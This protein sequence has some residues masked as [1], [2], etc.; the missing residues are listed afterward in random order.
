M[1]IKT[2]MRILPHSSQIGHHQKVYKNKFW[3]GRGALNL[4]SLLKQLQLSY[5]YFSS[6]QS[7]SHVGLFPPHEPQHARPPCPSPTPGV[8]QNPRPLSRWCHPTILSSVV[9]FSSCP[10]SF[11]PSGSFQVSQLFT[12]GG[13]S[14]GVSASTSVLP[15]NTQD[16]SPLGWTGW[17][18][19]QSKG[20]SRDFSNTTVQKHQFFGAQPS[21]QS[22]SHIHTWRLEKP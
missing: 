16:W 11:L 15:M 20:L 10:Q 22:N 7:L 14:I 3:R 21:S 12:S 9:P 17:I 2:T 1:Q 13:Q 18:S 5:C 4:Q 19:L 6:V 8:H